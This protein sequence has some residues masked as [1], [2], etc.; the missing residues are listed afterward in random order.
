MPEGKPPEWTAQLPKE[1]REN[2]GLLKKL[3]GF[4]TIAELANSYLSVEGKQVVPSK[5]AKPEEVQGFYERLGKPKTKE[6]YSMAGDKDAAP[7]IEGAYSMH[8]TDAQA[9]FIWEQ[10]CKDRQETADRQAKELAES[11]A[12]LKR[13]YGGKYN[14]AIAFYRRGAGGI[15]NELKSH[16]LAGKPQIVRALIAYGRSISEAGGAAES[17]GAAQPVS[18]MRGRGFNYKTTEEYLK[19]DT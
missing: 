5:D 16:G 4:K 18:V 8:L 2:A 12:V 19:H 14:E 7:F 11:D 13:E 10:A 17:G 3:G 9:T 6:G 15:L 1:I